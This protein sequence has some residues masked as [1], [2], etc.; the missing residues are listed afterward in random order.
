MWSKLLLWVVISEHLYYQGLLYLS[1]Q[2]GKKWTCFYKKKQRDG[3]SICTT[4]FSD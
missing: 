3:D 1:L 2:N 4:K